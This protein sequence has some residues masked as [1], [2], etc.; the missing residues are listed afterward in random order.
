MKEELKE[1]IEVIR[2]ALDEIERILL[3]KK[4]NDK[5]EL[6][7]ISEVARLTG[8]HYQTIFRYVKEGRVKTVRLNKKHLIPKEEL[9]KF[10]KSTT[11]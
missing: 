8:L 3:E 5:R 11:N 4:E 6:Y 7:S 9:R 1:Y 2:S 10:Y